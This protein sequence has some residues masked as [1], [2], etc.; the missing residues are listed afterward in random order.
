MHLKHFRRGP[1]KYIFRRL[2]KIK[3]DEWLMMT[4]VRVYFINI[5]TVKVHWIFFV[6][7]YNFMNDYIMQETIWLL[8][9]RKSARP[10]IATI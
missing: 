9:T 10:A 7:V 4:S 2:R 3:N 6:V 5:K 8:F 1:K